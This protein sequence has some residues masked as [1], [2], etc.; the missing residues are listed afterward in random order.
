MGSHKKPDIVPE[1]GPVAVGYSGAWPRA[2]IRDDMIR[3]DTAAEWRP[4]DMAGRLLMRFANDVANQGMGV[5]AAL[6]AIEDAQRLGAS[7]SEHVAAIRESMRRTAGYVRDVEM[8]IAP[9]GKAT[10]PNT[11]TIIEACL[12]QLSTGEDCSRMVLGR[13]PYDLW[14]VAVGSEQLEVT[15]LHLLTNAL[16]ATRDSGEVRLDAV[17]VELQP[18]QAARLGIKA[19]EYVRISVLDTGVGLK[20]ELALRAFEPFFSTWGQ[21]QPWR[22]LG[23]TKVKSLA[24]S[25]GGAC[26]LRDMPG[27]GTRATVLLPRA[28]SSS[29][30]LSHARRSSMPEFSPSRFLIVDDEPLVVSGL[31]RWLNRGG[32]SV[33]IARDSASAQSLLDSGVKIDVAIVDLRL[34]STLGIEVARRIRVTRPGTIVLLST[35]YLGELPAEAL[36]QSLT[37]LPVLRKPFTVHDLMDAVRQAQQWRRGVPGG[38]R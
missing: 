19:G 31:A 17:N 5:E 8:L 28:L 29:A 35:G 23:L 7:I 36:E 14:P 20:P 16:E 18:P 21:D 4:S 34:G 24:E 12:E 11:V 27:I 9:G 30:T 1:R 37:Q 32:H 25:S 2:R 33:E 26:E 38:E 15:L 22:G 3:S 6:D 13:F 10:T